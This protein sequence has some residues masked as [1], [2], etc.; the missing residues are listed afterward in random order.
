MKST[1]NLVLCMSCFDPRN[2]FFTFNLE[3]LLRLAW[4]YPFEFSEVALSEL[5]SQLENFIFDG[6]HR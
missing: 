4:Y 5:E 2:S 6:A 1:H 3:K